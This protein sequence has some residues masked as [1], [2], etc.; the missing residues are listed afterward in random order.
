MT[1]NSCGCNER[2]IYV[3]FSEDRGGAFTY[4]FY[5]FNIKV[6]TNLTTILYLK[7][8]VNNLTI[9]LRINII[10]EFNLINWSLYKSCVLE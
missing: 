5:F 10:V 1:E 3:Q 8:M 6:V 7:D 9:L 2:G 4:Y